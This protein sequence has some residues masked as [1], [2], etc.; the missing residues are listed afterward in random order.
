M[1]VNVGKMHSTSSPMRKISRTV[2]LVRSRR[3]DLKNLSEYLRPGLYLLRSDLRTWTRLTGNVRHFRSMSSFVAQP[4]SLDF[5]AMMKE[6]LIQLCTP[7][8]FVTKKS[9]GTAHLVRNASDLLF[10]DLEQRSV[11][12]RLRIQRSDERYEGFRELLSRYVPMPKFQVLDP[13]NIREELL[14]TVSF[15]SLP[16]AAQLVSLRNLLQMLATAARFECKAA[17][18]G[19]YERLTS[20]LPRDSWPDSLQVA[21]SPATLERLVKNALFVPSHGDLSR[22][23]IRILVG[24]PESLTVVDW[25]PRFLRERP[26]W[27]DSIS[28]IAR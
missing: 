20:L 11:V 10:V 18:E 24:K 2:L 28:V 26:F 8:V 21:L 15:D 16:L 25:E 17:P 12:R 5:R 14:E 3:H 4:N 22:T 27:F 1:L 23:N 7:P 13:T 9:T 6:R 19:F